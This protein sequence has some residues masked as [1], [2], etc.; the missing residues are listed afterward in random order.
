MSKALPERPDLE[1]LKKQAK[2]LLKQ[3]RAG[4]RDAVAR[5]ASDEAGKLTLIG[6]QRVIARDYGFPSWAKLKLHVETREHVLATARLV[7]AVA[8][9]DASTLKALLAE[10][11]ELGRQSV[12]A[13]AVLADMDTLR[14]WVKRNSEF[15]R[16]KGGLCDTEALGYVC[17]GRLGGDESARL[18]CADLLLANGADPNAT[19]IDNDFDKGLRLPILYAAVGRNDYPRLAERLLAAGA[20]ANDGE[21]IYHAAEM[22]HVGCL[23]ALQK[24]GADFSARDPKWKN[25]PLYFLVGWPPTMEGS[26][27]SRAGVLWLLDHGADPN[28]VSEEKSEAPLHRAIQNSWDL[29]LIRHFLD[30]GANPN[31]RRA[32]GKSLL[33]LAV[34]TGRQDIAAVLLEHGAVNDAT[35]AEQFLGACAAAN[36][37]EA[38]RLFRAHPEWREQLV[39][40]ASELAQTVAI[41]GPAAIIDL[42]A[43]FGLPIDR[44]AKNGERP[45]HMA[46]WHGVADVARRLIAHGADLNRPESQ[47]HAPPLG[48]CLHGSL[49]CRAPRG[50]YPAVADALLAAGASLPPAEYGYGSPDVAAVVRRHLAKLSPTKSGS[51]VP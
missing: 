2:D 17:L 6:A 35:E 38:R 13:A 39:E 19:W 45:L 36:A 14:A 15:A 41:R 9:G 37:S 16:A 24:A 29:D 44:T 34:R 32:D 43:E 8:N 33:A 42:F 1:Q 51:K 25:T 7:A 12:S 48:W 3:A 50:D 11:P 4:D 10:R 40:E 22:N 28:V 18:A 21:S 23:E 49:N 30:H 26:K 31:A 5:L 47:Y 20:K 27:K 46:A